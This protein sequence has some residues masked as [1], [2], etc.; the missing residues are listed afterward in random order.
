MGHFVTLN[1]ALNLIKNLNE[2]WATVR[3]AALSDRGVLEGFVSTYVNTLFPVAFSGKQDSPVF[4]SQCVR[5][6]AIHQ[7]VVQAPS[8]PVVGN[9]LLVRAVER[10]LG[11]ALLLSLEGE[12]MDSFLETLNRFHTGASACLLPAFGDCVQSWGDLLGDGCYAHIFAVDGPKALP[13]AFKIYHRMDG[14]VPDLAYGHSVWDMG[15]VETQGGGERF[16]V[17][18]PR[19]GRE[20]NSEGESLRLLAGDALV[21]EMLSIVTAGANEHRRGVCHGDLRT[22]NILRNEEGSKWIAIDH[23]HSTLRGNPDGRRVWHPCL[24]YSSESSRANPDASHFLFLNERVDVLYMG[25]TLLD[26]LLGENVTF[27]VLRHFQENPGAEKYA[28][29]PEPLR[30]ILHRAVS[31]RPECVFGDLIEMERAI[32]ALL[33]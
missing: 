1:P 27:D 7:M 15:M 33:S 31:E 25:V 22:T 9:A 5:I 24:H 14:I 11:V 29:I 23:N 30:D 26:I 21:R 3:T 28:S 18:M 20:L 17:L 19:L 12:P 16:Y 2:E 13:L 6:N 32:G 10:A 8:S 4:A